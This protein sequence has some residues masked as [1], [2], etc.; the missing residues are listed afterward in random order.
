MLF[1][2]FVKTN[3]NTYHMLFIGFVNTDLDLSTPISPQYG[4]AQGLKKLRGAAAQPRTTQALRRG[5]APQATQV[6]SANAK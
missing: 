1:I 5:N 2:G 4:P 6:T 3:F